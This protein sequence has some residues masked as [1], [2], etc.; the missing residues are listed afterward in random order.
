MNNNKLCLEYSHIEKLKVFD[1]PP[2]DDN[3]TDLDITDFLLQH[4]RIFIK[5][6]KSPQIESPP[7][8]IKGQFILRLSLKENG[9]S[10]GCLE[11]DFCA[12]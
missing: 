11:F 4:P 6:W 2:Y 12:K 1:L 5:N 3:I 9:I 8:L 7:F 10:I